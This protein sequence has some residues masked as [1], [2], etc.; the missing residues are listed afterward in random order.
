VGEA[1]TLL[2]SDGY[3][4]GADLVVPAGDLVGAVLIAPA[5]GVPRR[6]YG[7]FA[8]FLAD[9]GLAVLT[10]DYRGIGRSRSLPMASFKAQ[11]HDWAELDLTAAVAELKRR[12]PSAPLLWFGHSVG[13]QLFGL[14]EDSGV[15]GALFLASQSGY[16]RNWHGRG[17]LAMFAV[18]HALIPG[19]VTTL[20]YLPMKAFRQGED[21]PGGVAAEWATWGRHPDY[22]WSYAQPRGGRSFSSYRG[23]LFLLAISDDAYAPPDSVRALQ[24]FYT[25]ARST[26]RVVRPE[27]VGAKSIG[28]FGFFKPSFQKTLWTEVRDWLL[29]RARPSPASSQP[30]A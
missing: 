18:W 27:D 26:M 23:D 15:R 14:L 21:L 6:L 28:H 3:A 30:A 25:A 10:L 24:H 29:E 5:M 8:Q 2:A 13:G 22:I 9:S 7:S 4:L 19:F 1:I 11:L 16:W 17:R 12:F 20:G